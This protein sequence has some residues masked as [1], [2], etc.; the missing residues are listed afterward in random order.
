MG[1]F[2]KLFGR[3][4]EPKGE[5]RGEYRLLN[6]YSPVF[7]RFGGSIYESELVRAAINAIAVQCGKLEV[8]I[9]GSA[10]PSLQSKLKKG[11]NE[12][13]SW[14]QFL[15]RLATILYV[16]NTAFI[17]PIFDQYG[18]VSGIFPV[19]PDRCEVVQYKVGKEIKPYLRYTFNILHVTM[20]LTL[21][22]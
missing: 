22:I 1:L 9:Q 8:T 17:V 4:P 3:K 6:G 2:D 19:L 16:H 12:I 13:Q 7:N 11:P 5:Y 10:K 21:K 14:S 20:I 18:E 15:A